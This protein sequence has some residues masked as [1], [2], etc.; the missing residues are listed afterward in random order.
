MP[1]FNGRL[2]LPALEMGDYMDVEIPV[3]TSSDNFMIDIELI[4]YLGKVSNQRINLQTM[5]N[6][7]S[8]MELT[9]ADIGTQKVVFYPDELGDVDVDRHIPLS[10]N[11]PNGIAIIFGTQNYNDVR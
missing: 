3:I 2:S 5:R 8:P 7:R 1:E 11:N 9:I 10:R 6:Y 4:D